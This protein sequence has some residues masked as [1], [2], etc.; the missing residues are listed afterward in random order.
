[1]SGSSEPCA[2]RLP[3]LELVAD[4][5]H[6]SWMEGKLAQGIISR[7]AEDGEEL[8]VPY[9]R[10]SERQKDQDRRLVKTVYEA[11]ELALGQGSSR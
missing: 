1:M 9:A 8:M 11:I 7:K 2:I 10:L 3:D 6:Q 4:L 5:V